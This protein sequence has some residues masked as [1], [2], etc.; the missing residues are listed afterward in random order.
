MSHKPHSSCVYPKLAHPGCPSRV[1]NWE[2]RSKVI[3]VRCHE[4]GRWFEAKVSLCRYKCCP[5]F[6][7]I[8]KDYLPGGDVLDMTGLYH[9]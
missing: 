2:V 3:F 7:W 6:I 9:E 4:T 1:T 5:D 8:E